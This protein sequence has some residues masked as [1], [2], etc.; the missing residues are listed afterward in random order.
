MSLTITLITA[1]LLGLFTSVIATG[2]VSFLIFRSALLGAYRKSIA[3]VFGSSLMEMI[4]CGI[5]VFSVSFLVQ[6]SQRVVV[7]SKAIGAAVSIFVGLYFLFHRYRR[8]HLQKTASLNNGFPLSSFLLGFV[9]VLL[10]PSIIL[11]WS[12]AITLLLSFEA[13]AVLTALQALG[14]MLATGIGVVSG[15]LLM[16]YCAHFY[17]GKT[18]GTMIKRTIRVMGALLVILGFYLLYSLLDVFLP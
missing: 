6:Q 4:Y 8:F 10:N 9:L 1:F 11:T 13:I 5:A 17:K 14:F 2:P 12:V 15:S 7:T 16:V 3:M 18:T